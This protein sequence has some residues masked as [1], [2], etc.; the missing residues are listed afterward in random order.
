[1]PLFRKSTPGR[2]SINKAEKLSNNL[3]KLLNK[4]KKNK[5]RLFNKRIENKTRVWRELQRQEKEAENLL[6]RIKSHL[7]EGIRKLK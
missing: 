2:S 1:M 4:I 7:Q 3:E 5:D 6:V